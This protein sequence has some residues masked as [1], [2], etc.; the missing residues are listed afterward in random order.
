MSFK[1]APVHQAYIEPQ[2]CVPR[3]S[4]ARVGDERAYAM[5]TPSI[6]RAGKG[7]E[8]F[9]KQASTIYTLL[10][11]QIQLYFDRKHASDFSGLSCSID[12]ASCTCAPA[13][14]T[15]TRWAACCG[16]PGPQSVEAF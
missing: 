15:A 7:L 13:P 4:S 6:G 9:K 2:G 3:A 5:L 14:A 10:V 8:G 1:T 16:C 12:L 11:H